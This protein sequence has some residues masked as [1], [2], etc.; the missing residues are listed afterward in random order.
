MPQLPSDWLRER[1]LIYFEP[2]AANTIWSYARE[3]AENQTEYS[4]EAEKAFQS[5]IEFGAV[6]FA[7][8]PLYRGDIS[9]GEKGLLTDFSP[10]ER[11]FPVHVPDSAA[12]DAVFKTNCGPFMEHTQK[13][14]SELR[15]W[16]VFTFAGD[17][18][19][20]ELLGISGDVNVLADQEIMETTINALAER[21]TRAGLGDR[22]VESGLLATQGL[23]WFAKLALLRSEDY[24][25]ARHLN[26]VR[27]YLPGLGMAT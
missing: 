21:Y 4:T 11:I 22:V 24:T 12:A 16:D 1:G 9:A 26:F 6:D 8:E 10:V 2:S 25:N 14:P 27:R 13:R 3:W 23:V 5:F 17:M 7:L 15:P 18:S 19:K 20:M